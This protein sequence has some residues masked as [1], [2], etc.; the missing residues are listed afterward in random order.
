MYLDS[1]WLDAYRKHLLTSFNMQDR[2]SCQSVCHSKVMLS[3]IAFT[4]EQSFSSVLDLLHTTLHSP[5]SN[6][7]SRQ[8]PASM[9]QRESHVF[10]DTHVCHLSG[11][12]QSLKRSASDK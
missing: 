6:L 11:F 8:L 12:I 1:V 3:L 10:S 9:A 4:A 2:S 5:Q 7:S